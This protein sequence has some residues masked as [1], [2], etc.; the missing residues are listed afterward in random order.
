MPTLPID[1]RIA[2]LLALLIGAWSLAI[3]GCADQ[4]QSSATFRIP[5]AEYAL[6]FEGAK[7]VLRDHQF[8]L[9]R[10]DAR[11]GILTSSPASSAGWATPWIDHAQSASASNA[12]LIQRRRR[13]ATVRFSPVGDETNRANA[14]DPVGQDLRDFEGTIEVSVSVLI[15]QVYRPG[16]R[17][18]PAS[19]RL[20]TFT[21]DPRENLT[22]PQQLVTRIVGSDPKL[23]SR[24][25]DHLV[26]N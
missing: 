3:G 19:I 11:A 10:V 16:R 15:E 18:S 7:Q 5:A 9:E 6:Y 26:A 21:D 22:G 2:R 13:I 20:T 23:A 1:A 12:D 14:V 8:D 17:L 4:Q 25:S 24:L